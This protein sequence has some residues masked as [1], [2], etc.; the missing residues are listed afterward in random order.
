VSY[1]PEYETYFGRLGRRQRHPAVRSR[2]SALAYAMR[3]LNA[4]EALGL[5]AKIWGPLP[6]HADSGHIHIVAL[7]TYRQV[8]RLFPSEELIRDYGSLEAPA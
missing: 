1:D 5:P 7:A 2:K 3:E 8:K 4:V 6:H